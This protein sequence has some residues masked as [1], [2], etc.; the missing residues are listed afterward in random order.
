MRIL[1]AED[2]PVSRRVL[3]A[4]LIKL[5]HETLGV[6]D[7]HQT[8]EVLRGDDA[9][10]LAILDWM[11]P[12]MDGVEVCRRLREER[13]DTPLYIILLT[14]RGRRQ[15][16]IEGL[17]AGADDYITKPFDRDELGARI[18]VGERVVGLQA[19]LSN[20]VREL[21]DALAHVKTLQGIL[22][23]CMYCHKIMDDEKSWQRLEKYIEAH[24]DA[25]FSHGICPDCKKK[26][27]AELER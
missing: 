9:P 11:M 3:E 15:D 7:G 19:V 23:I 16:V 10:S 17:Q 20:R 26:Y 22:S 14:A 12:G 4:T 24:S 18:R 25:A 8:W 21:K 6:V 1:L 5:G 27:L 2:D 13:P